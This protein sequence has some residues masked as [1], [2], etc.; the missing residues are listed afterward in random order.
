MAIV[1]S[2]EAGQSKNGIEHVL[3]GL[4]SANSGP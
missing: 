1:L 2:V 4:L 3:N